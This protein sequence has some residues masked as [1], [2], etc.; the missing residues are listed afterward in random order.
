[1]TRYVSD[2]KTSFSVFGRQCIV[3]VCMQIRYL[4]AIGGNYIAETTR[5][6]LRGVID[7]NIITLRVQPVKAERYVIDGCLSLCLTAAFVLC[8]VW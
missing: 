5:G 6:V 3:A 7:I 1:M 4:G 2:H 8:I